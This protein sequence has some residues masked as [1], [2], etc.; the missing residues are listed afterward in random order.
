MKTRFY[1]FLKFVSKIFSLVE[2]EDHEL[3]VKTHID[4]FRKMWKENPIPPLRA[5]RKNVEPI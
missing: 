5:L 1:S 4:H 2:I 3:V